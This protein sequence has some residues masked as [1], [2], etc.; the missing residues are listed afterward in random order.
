[1]VR[2]AS[3]LL[4]QYLWIDF[5]CIFQDSLEDWSTQAKDMATVYSNSYLNL[6]ASKSSDS[7]GGLFTS[8]D[9]ARLQSFQLRAQSSRVYF[10]SE[11]TSQEDLS[12]H[13]PLHKQ[14]WVVQE[15]FLSPRVLYFGEM[16]VHWGCLQCMTSENMTVG[17]AC[18][19]PQRLKTLDFAFN[20]L[21]I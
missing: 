4:V 7:S 9:C 11:N 12:F 2:V 3:R 21:E 17:L 13:S 14:A 18:N 6:A 19:F 10:C 15:R 16:Q 1:M 8:R 20:M 5:L